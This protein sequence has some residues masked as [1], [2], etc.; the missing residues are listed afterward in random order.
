MIVLST[1]LESS[2]NFLFINIKKILQNLVQGGV[3]REKGGVK[4]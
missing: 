4:V 3:V 1:F 2:L